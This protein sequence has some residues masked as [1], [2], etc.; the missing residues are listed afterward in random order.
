MLAHSSPLPLVI[1]HF[2]EYHNITTEDEERTTLPLMQ[3]DHVRRVRHLMPFSNLQRLIVVMDEEYPILE[4]LVIG[5]QSDIE[6]G[7]LIFP[8]TFQAPRLRQL[9]LNG[10]TLHVGSR[11]LTAAVSLVALCLK[12]DQPSTYFHPNTLLRWLSFT[13]QLETL[14]IYFLSAV[15][16]LDVER[17]LTH[18]PIITAVTLSNSHHL[19]FEA[20]ALNW[21]RS[22]IGSP[23]L[24]PKSFKSTSSTNSRFPSLVYFS[25]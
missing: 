25:L 2:R 3:R 8:E 23:P 22:F 12:M 9:V 4:V 10:F 11:L 19:S 17:Q 24:A 7:N 16:N 15:P 21:K 18:T 20:L 5:D 14:M 13:H 1:D 6:G